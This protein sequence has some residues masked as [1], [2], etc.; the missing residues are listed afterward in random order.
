MRE[1]AQWLVD[2]GKPMWNLEDLSPVKINNPSDEF[3]VM[4]IDE[5]SVAA[6][7]LSFEDRF[8]WPHVALNTS[9][10]IHKLSIRRKFAGKGYA[11]M[12]IGHAKKL[13]LA[14]SIYY[15]RLDCDPHRKGLTNFY[16][17][18]GFSLVELKTISTKKLGTIDLAMYEMN[19]IY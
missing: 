15:L 1:A 17:N 11:E 19:F 4:W 14:K 13:C 8:F 10:F 2:I 16:E 6:M 3:I 12:L 18:C 5:E 7:T 9:G